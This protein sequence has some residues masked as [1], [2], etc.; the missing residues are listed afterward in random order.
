MKLWSDHEGHVDVVFGGTHALLNEVGDMTSSSLMKTMTVAR[1]LG[2]I[3]IWMSLVLLKS[4]LL[5][6]KVLDIV[7]HFPGPIQPHLL[8][9]M[10]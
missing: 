4:H 10:E 5:F 1:K 9:L 2:D 3:T 7:N 6:S 8:G